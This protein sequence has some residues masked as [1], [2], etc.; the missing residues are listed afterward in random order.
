MADNKL[1]WVGIQNNKFVFGEVSFVETNKCLRVVGRCPITDRIFI[2]KDC[3][4]AITSTSYNDNVII[5]YNNYDDVKPHIR[6]LIDMVETRL[7][8]LNKSIDIKQALHSEL[9]K[10]EGGFYIDSDKANN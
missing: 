5:Y 9:I 6:T 8:T 3:L 10:A 2:P 4:G 7:Q 1:K